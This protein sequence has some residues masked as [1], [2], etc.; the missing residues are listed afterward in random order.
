M[1]DT[2]SSCLQIYDGANSSARNIATL[3]GGWMPTVTTYDSSGHQM[4]IYFED[5]SASDK[6]FMG[7]YKV[8]RY[9]DH[10]RADTSNML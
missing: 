1:V 8:G 7:W 10:I 9:M 2:R 3:T 5:S 4:L 6:S